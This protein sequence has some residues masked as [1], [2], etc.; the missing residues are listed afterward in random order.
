MHPLLIET[1]DHELYVQMDHPMTKDHSIAFIAYSTSDRIHLCKLYPEQ[2]PAARFAY[3]GPGTVFAFC[4]KHGLFCE[5]NVRGPRH[6]P[7]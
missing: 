7:R 5:E 1:I 2:S 6:R 3:T 4:N